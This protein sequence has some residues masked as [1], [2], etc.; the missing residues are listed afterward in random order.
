MDEP[1]RPAP[2]TTRECLEKNE[3]HVIDVAGTY[4][5]PKERAFAVNKLALKDGTTIVLSPPEGELRD[6]FARDHDGLTM[7][8]RGRIFTGMIPEK[9]DIIG[10]TTEPYLLELEKIETLRSQG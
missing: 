7:I 8:I 10:R 5:F 2:C 1:A 3:G 4:V 6:H 9:Y